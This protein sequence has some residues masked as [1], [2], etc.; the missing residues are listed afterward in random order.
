[1]KSSNSANVLQV[2]KIIP[3]EKGSA[4]FVKE[5][6]VNILGFLGQT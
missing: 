1:M 3:I 2:V 5:K 6:V 4:N